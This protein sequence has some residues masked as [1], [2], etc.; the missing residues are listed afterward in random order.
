M[1][2]AWGNSKEHTSHPWYNF[3]KLCPIYY[4]WHNLNSTL[5][6]AVSPTSGVSWWEDPGR[7]W[8][9]P[10]PCYEILHSFQLGRKEKWNNMEKLTEMQRRGQLSTVS[11]IS[12]ERSQNI[13]WT[14]IVGKMISS[15]MCVDW[16]NRIN[17]HQFLLTPLQFFIFYL[18][19][20][21]M[22]FLKLILRYFTTEKEIQ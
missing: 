8:W 10:V 6:F 18:G 12:A 1:E 16:Q 22:F 11:P 17:F 7:F 4:F 9:I 13:I 20:Y 2:W 5:Y 3:V 21:Y 19:G 15:G 14:M